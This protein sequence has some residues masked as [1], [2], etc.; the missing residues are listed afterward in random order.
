[1]LSGRVGSGNAEQDG[2]ENGTEVKSLVSE[3]RIFYRVLIFYSI[4]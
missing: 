2:T 3:G 1:M 4:S